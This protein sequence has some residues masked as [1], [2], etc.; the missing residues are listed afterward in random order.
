MDIPMILEKIRPGAQYTLGGDTYDTLEWK[1]STEKPTE[2]ELVAAE[3]GAKIVKAAK[4]E[5]LRLEALETS[6]RIAEAT[7]TDEGRTWLQA[8][9]DLIAAE[10]EKL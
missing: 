8:N 4:I 7:L 6:R 5:M 3:S 9:R 1:D 2:A 10:R